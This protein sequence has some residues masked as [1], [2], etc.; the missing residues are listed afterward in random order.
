MIRRLSCQYDQ[1]Q[2]SGQKSR[3][4]HLLS[5]TKLPS[6]GLFQCGGNIFLGM[7]YDHRRGIRLRSNHRLLLQLFLGLNC[8]LIEIFMCRP[9]ASCAEAFGDD[10]AELEKRGQS[11]VIDDYHVL[12]LYY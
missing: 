12:S 8:A 1:S 3:D 2:P 4:G 10:L 6:L 11:A 9:W 7:P 5:R